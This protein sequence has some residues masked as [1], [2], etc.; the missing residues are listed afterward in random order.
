MAVER[1][2][3]SQTDTFLSDIDLRNKEFYAA[4]RTAT[5]GTLCAAGDF[6]DGVISE[7][8]AAGLHTS[9]KTDNQVKAIAGEVIN[10]GQKVTPDADGKFVVA[11]TADDEVFGTA[12]SKANAEDDLFTIEVD[13]QKIDAA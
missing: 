7:G 10:V 2:T 8:K 6:C 3:G 1:F 9:I 13:R 12:I 11:D 4:K 5:G